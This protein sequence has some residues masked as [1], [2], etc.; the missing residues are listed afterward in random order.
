MTRI[1]DADDADFAAMADGGRVGPL[2]VVAGG[3]E[4]AEILAMLRGL[5]SGIRADFAPAAWMIAE[6][7]EI[8]GLCSIVKPPGSDGAV[9]IGYGVAASYR[10]RGTA[11]RAVR[12]VL[13]WARSDGR[14]AA[15]HAETSVGNP[16]SQ[17]V[18]ERN[19]F[20]RT[21]TRID[22]EDGELICWAAATAV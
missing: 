6:A 2:T 19:G 3:I 15:I 4:T 20:V 13:D 7:D 11:T 5:A 9:E 8:V 10:G 16:A 1:V 17:I 21:G 22:N 12:A 14:V 18:L